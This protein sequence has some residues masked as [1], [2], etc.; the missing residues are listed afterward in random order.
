MLE[1]LARASF[2]SA[3]V[4]CAV[5]TINRI[6]RLSPGVR[7][8]LWWCAAAKFV[9]TLAWITPVAVPLLPPSTSA[10]AFVANPGG[11]ASENI[12]EDF[13][14]EV[15]P[16]LRGAGVRQPN[17]IPWLV[18]LLGLWAAGT[19][20]S[21]GFAGR[22]W[23]QTR[24]V[25]RRSVRAGAQLQRSATELAT[26]FALRRVPEVRAS[27]EVESPLIAGLRK[28]VILVPANRFPQ[29]SQEQQRMALC[30][31]LA[32]VHR[33]D[34][35]L[36]CV[37]ALAE[38][39]FF[40][41]PLAR[42]A[43]REYVFW[44]EAACDAAVLVA[45]DTA[46]QA[47]GR[48]LL[49]LGVARPTGA[50][51]AAGAA[52]SF[53]N[54]KRR[55]TMLTQPSKPSAPAR[56]IAAGAVALAVVAIAPLR[57]VARPSAAAP[58]E[59]PVAD[60]AGAMLPVRPLPVLQSEIEPQPK[61]KAQLEREVRELREQQDEVNFVFLMG[62]RQTMMSGT[63][64][65]VER[66][67][68]Q[69][70]GDEQL[71]WFRRD[72]REYVVRDPDVLRELQ[73]IWE[74]VSRLGDE[75][76]EVGSRQ[77]VLGTRQGEIGTRQGKLGTEQGILGSRQGELASRHGQLAAREARKITA[78]ERAEIEREQQQLDRQMRELDREMAVLGDKMRELEAPMRD[79]GDQ[80]EVLGREMEVLGRKMEEASA[81]ANAD[82]RRLIDKAVAA[83]AAQRVR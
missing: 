9:V 67:R 21:I 42:L 2:D 26:L 10:G 81:K 82:M 59:A 55:I 3:L 14:A 83:G 58:L 36:G 63:R 4:V 64:G 54:L 35:W 69:Q 78:A 8:A 6:V 11:T 75:Q 53:S 43:T 19:T 76:G 49:D 37:P 47:Y 29:L 73:R 50:L 71:L 15:Q 20:V 22:R 33:G 46:P 7:A 52:W 31:E 16:G 13:D 65:D 51:A 28:P 32:H 66:A 48:L 79:L 62:N 57:L 45:L 70:K 61:P 5:W 24:A 12:R 60:A 23:H 80:M 1:S 17:R 34:V 56:I 38:R 74:P 25:V 44:R 30:H 27:D 39:I 18:V 72:G 40:F 77:G 41:H 68:Q